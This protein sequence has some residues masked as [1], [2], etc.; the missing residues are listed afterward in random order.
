MRTTSKPPGLRMVG[1]TAYA[2]AGT[3]KPCPKRA[4]L[5]QHPEPPRNNDDAPS[6]ETSSSTAK[7]AKLREKRKEIWRMAEAATRY[8]R[9]RLTFHDAISQ[10]QRMEI[11]EGRDHP[12]ADSDDRDPVVRH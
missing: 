11:P 2:P 4:R 12:I 3:E 1:G 8:W 9:V 7:N 6:T 5:F 10:A